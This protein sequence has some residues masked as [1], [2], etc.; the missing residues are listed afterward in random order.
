MLLAGISLPLFP[1]ASICGRDSVQ[2][3]G[4]SDDA[5]GTSRC[6]SGFVAGL[7]LRRTDSE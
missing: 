6:G 2:T 7:A 1:C 4:L 5:S 3:N